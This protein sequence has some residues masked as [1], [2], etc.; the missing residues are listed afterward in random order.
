MLADGKKG[1]V[2]HNPEIANQADLQYK[3]LFVDGIDIADY[4]LLTGANDRT[5]IVDTCDKFSLRFLYD[6]KSYLLESLTPATNFLLTF[7]K[8]LVTSD[9]PGIRG[10]VRAV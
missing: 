8:K 7:F 2:E 3:Y 10:W 6:C 9:A 1:G 4:W 5:F